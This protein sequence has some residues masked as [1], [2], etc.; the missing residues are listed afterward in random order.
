MAAILNFTV[1]AISEKRSNY[2][3]MSGTTDNRMMDTSTWISA[4]AVSL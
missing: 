2:T 3:S 4:A 1:N